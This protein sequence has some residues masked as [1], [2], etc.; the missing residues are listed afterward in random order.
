MVPYTIR[1]N[2]EALISS[3]RTR[4]GLSSNSRA[5]VSK[6][7]C[8]RQSILKPILQVLQGLGRPTEGSTYIYPTYTCLYF[9]KKQ[10]G[11]TIGLNNNHPNFEVNLRSVMLLI[12]CMA[13]CAGVT[14]IPKGHRV[15]QGLRSRRTHNNPLSFVTVALQ[16]KYVVPCQLSTFFRGG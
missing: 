10:C 12:L 16:K 15:S 3:C 6:K 9:P 13:P 1:A 2:H 5:K 8:T 14:W 11:S 7:T 4:T